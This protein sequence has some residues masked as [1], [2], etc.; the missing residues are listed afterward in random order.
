MAKN[1]ILCLDGTANEYGKH[2]TNV[3]HLFEA[4]ARDVEQTAYYDPG[5]GTF[6]SIGIPFAQPVGVLLGKAFGLGL[7]QNLA[8]AYSY[9]MDHYES[10]DRVFVFGFSRGA[11]TARALA[12]MLHKCGLLEKGSGNLV[13]Y[14]VKIY[15]QKENGKIRR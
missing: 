3:V 9:L 13:P 1:I 10:G 2:K 15:N 12:G 7:R 4:A 8:E 6:S 14:A 5:V 11:F